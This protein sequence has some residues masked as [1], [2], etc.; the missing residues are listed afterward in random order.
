[1]WTRYD[2]LSALSFF[3]L[4]SLFGIF[5]GFELLLAAVLAAVFHEVGHLAVL[6]L[7]S[8]EEGRLLFHASGLE[9]RREERR[10]LSYPQ[11]LLSVLA[12]PAMNILWAAALARIATEESW[13]T[14]ILLAGAQL[15]L[16]LFN[17]LPILPL[18][19]GRAAELLL[20]WLVE[21][22]FAYRVMRIMSLAVS[23]AFLLFALALLFAGGRGFLLFAAAMLFFLVLREL[24]LVKTP[25]NG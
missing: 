3:L 11:E 23:T 8:A 14:G 6:R 18:D 21:P 7:F 19:G 15:M 24:G 22:F 13:E 4:L 12:G 17:L 1:M 25:V 9:W 2:A 16:G 10:L 20:A 5:A